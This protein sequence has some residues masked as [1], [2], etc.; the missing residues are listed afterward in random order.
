MGCSV[1]P[2]DFCS[3]FVQIGYLA[4]MMSMILFEKRLMKTIRIMSTLISPKW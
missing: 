2:M 4:I 3:V 1:T